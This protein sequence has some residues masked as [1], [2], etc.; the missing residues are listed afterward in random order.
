MG[1]AGTKAHVATVFQNVTHHRRVNER[2][3]QIGQKMT[4]SM[5]G[6]MARVIDAM[7]CS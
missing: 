4:V 3:L 6:S 1:N 2:E 7:V 5:S